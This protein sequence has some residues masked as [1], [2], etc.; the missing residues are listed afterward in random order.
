M[1]LIS[2]RVVSGGQTGVDRAALDAALELKLPCGGWCPKGRKAEDGPIPARYPLKE[3]ES[4]SYPVRTEANVKDS[5]GTLILTWG[6]PTGGTLLS[7]ELAE[8]HRKPFQVIDMNA[9]PSSTE[10]TRWLVANM[11][12]TLNVAGPRQGKEDRVYQKALPF[13]RDVLREWLKQISK[14]S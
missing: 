5:D 12:Y 11:I 6:P 10:V 13:L 7:V 8:I 4:A 9:A 1:S 14:G 3:T 2:I